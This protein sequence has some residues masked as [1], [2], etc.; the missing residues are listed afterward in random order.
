MTK[1]L[2]TSIAIASFFPFYFWVMKATASRAV[3]VPSSHLDALISVQ[4]WAIVPYA[5]LWVYVSL[6]AAFAA[7]IK[8]LL[9][10]AAVALV[11][12]TMGM[13]AYWIWPTCVA[14]AGIDWSQYP[15]LQFLKSSDAGGNAFPSLHVA[16]ALW[17][18][19]MLH[20]QLASIQAPRWVRLGNGIWCLAIVYSTLATRQHLLFDVV[21]GAI[22]AWAASWLV[23][24]ALRL[25]SRAEGAG[26]E[27]RF[28]H[29]ATKTRR[30]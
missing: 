13:C 11:M 12:A 26:I 17:A 6:P 18:G 30:P 25:R 14:P 5:S 24:R 8:A 29:Y 9:R 3:P 7:N 19:R 2:G 1:M 28:G 27:F 16:F 4:E 15:M 20:S 21:G 23:W 22:T 10:Y